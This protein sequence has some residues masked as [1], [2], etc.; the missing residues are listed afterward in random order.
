MLEDA[1]GCWKMLGDANTV[2]VV[3]RP[4]TTAEKWYLE[5]GKDKG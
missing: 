1:G 2:V 5:A 3:K 4:R